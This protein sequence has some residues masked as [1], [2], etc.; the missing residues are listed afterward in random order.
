MGSTVRKIAII[1]GTRPEAIKMAPVYHAIKAADGL[2][3][4]L[5][6]TGQ[7]REM[8]QQVFDWFNLT[9]DED[10]E[11]MKPDQT[12]NEVLSSAIVGLDEIITKHKPDAILAQGDTTTVL[13]AALASY[14]RQ[15]PF[16]HV[17][18]GLRTYD[19]ENPYPEEAFRQMTSRVARWNFA[20]TERSATALKNE[21]VN[22]VVHVIGNTVIDAL[23]QTAARNPEIG[24]DLKGDALCLITG[25]RR[26]NLDGGLARVFSAIR[27]LAS[28]FKTV[29][30]VYPVHLNPRVRQ[31]TDKLLSGVKNIHLIEPV[32]YPKMVALMQKARLILSDSGGVQEEAP[33]LGTPVL[34]LRETTERQE[35][36]ECGAAMLVGTDPE[37]IIFEAAKLLTNDTALSKMVIDRNPFG[38]GDSSLKIVEIIQLDLLQP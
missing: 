33:S 23:L 30:F 8:L 27:Q 2:T 15:V 21:K 36:V 4:L 29:D 17:E 31:E 14:N 11:L 20:P 24:L 32:A 35:A 28:R 5:I 38:R 22:G 19:L 26:E 37:K 16:G 12:L 13:A 9:P 25:H 7:H 6:S 34:V 3:P 1:V 18:A 10:L